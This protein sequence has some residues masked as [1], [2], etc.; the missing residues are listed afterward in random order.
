MIDQAYFIKR[1]RRRLRLIASAPPPPNPCP[2]PAP[3]DEQARRVTAFRDRTE[4]FR[5]GA[6][7]LPSWPFPLFDAEPSVRCEEVC[8][9]S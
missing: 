2:V 9:A 1:A 7:R 6:G 8:R 4:A 3:T 5:G